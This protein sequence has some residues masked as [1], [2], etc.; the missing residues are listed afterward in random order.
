MDVTQP[1]Q[2]A[3]AAESV[4]AHTDRRGLDALVNNAGIGLAWP[5]ELVPPELFRTQFAINVDGVIAVTQALLPLLRLAPGR[6]VMIGSISDRITMP[7]AG[8]L[9]ATKHALLAVTEAFRLE[10]AP[11][12]IRVVLIE[13]AGIRT[14]AIDKLDADVQRALQQFGTIGTQLY[15]H[16]F[17]SM[18]SRALAHEAHG[19]PP[20]VV[21]QVIL[22]ALESPRPKARYLV[23]K[24]ARLLA[25]VARLP[26]F[27]LDALRRRFFGL[28]GPGSM[29]RSAP[30]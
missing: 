26:P 14:D 17:R 9:T 2:I 29:L 1:D 20:E 27:A 4:R 28:P 5:L 18:T 25:L 19:S 7:F 15:G 8:P 23:G 10:L 22:Q 24:N 21:A 6:V 3:A 12:N 13:P 16:A 11:W 30:R